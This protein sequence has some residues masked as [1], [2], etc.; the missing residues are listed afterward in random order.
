MNDRGTAS[1]LN[2]SSDSS[3]VDFSTARDVQN[4]P[5]RESA[6]IALRRYFADLEGTAPTDLYA[7]VI[8]E[9]E[10]PLL[11]AVLEFTRGN[12]SRASEIL[13]INRSTLRK[14]LRAHGLHN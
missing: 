13:G 3:V 4:R 9:V 2:G 14:K 11:R 10:K 6:E 8:N 1:R 5:L 12:Q 7:M